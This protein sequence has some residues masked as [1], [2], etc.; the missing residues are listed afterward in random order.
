MEATYDG[1]PYWSIDLPGL[2][3]SK[4]HALLNVAEDMGISFG[5]T[6]VD[7]AKFLTLHLDRPTVESAYRA[8]TSALSHKEAPVQADHRIAS[9]FC[10]ALKEWL[11]ETSQDELGRQ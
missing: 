6:L 3:R 8:L 5:G 4:A 11:Y 2:S 10:E 9:G 1:W 7:P